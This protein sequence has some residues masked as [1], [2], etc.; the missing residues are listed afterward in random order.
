LVKE[1]EAVRSFSLIIKYLWYTG[2][3]NLIFSLI[4]NVMDKKEI[5]RQETSA[6]MNEQRTISSPAVGVGAVVI[7]SNRL[8]L[9][10]RGSAPHKGMWAVPGGSVELG[11]SLQQAVERETREETGL[12]VAARD[13]IAVFQVI[14]RNDRGAIQFHYVI[15]DLIA[16]YVS[17]EAAAADDAADV[18]WF[19]A[20]DLQGVDVSSTTIELLKKIGFL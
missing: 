5:A 3:K 17:G 1:V 13:P 4:F 15:V 11:E 12:I 9:V 10:K 6:R 14:E 18:G 8:L 16:D 20:E 19:S 7:R 2:Y